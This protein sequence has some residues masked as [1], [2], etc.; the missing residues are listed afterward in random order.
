MLLHI[1]GEV[2]ATIRALIHPSHNVRAEL[3]RAARAHCGALVEPIPH[4]LMESIAHIVPVIATI[5]AARHH[6]ERAAAS[7]HNSRRTWERTFKAAARTLEGCARDAA[8]R[9]G[10][11]SARVKRKERI[12]DAGSGA[13][14]RL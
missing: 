14:K 12:R 1:I 11:R 4:R 8:A 2:A 6:S 10:D 5:G 9:R 3:L 7:A 13:A